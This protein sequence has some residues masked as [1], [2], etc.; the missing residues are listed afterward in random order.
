MT[1]KPDKIQELLD[2]MAK[3]SRAIIKEMAEICWYMRGS[4]TWDQALSLTYKEKQAISQ[5]IKENIERTEKTG[6]A[7][8]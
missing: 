4:V 1:L 6:L 7:L 5:V 8:L 2:G 3:D